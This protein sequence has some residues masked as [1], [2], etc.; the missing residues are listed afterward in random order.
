[1]KP[2]RFKIGQ[3]VTVKA[4][5]KEVTENVSGMVVDAWAVIPKFGEIVH[6]DYYERC[7]K[8]GQEWYIGLEEYSPHSFPESAFE[9]IVSDAVLIEELNTIEE[10]VTA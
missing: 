6:V 2:Q 9:P 3:P 4:R 10:T 5:P 7:H 1:M 8:T